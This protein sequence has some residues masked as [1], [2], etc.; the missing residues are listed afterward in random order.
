MSKERYCETPCNS[1]NNNNENESESEN[2]MNHTKR[3][4]NEGK[5]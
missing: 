4:I 5:R 3:M 1:N 2:D